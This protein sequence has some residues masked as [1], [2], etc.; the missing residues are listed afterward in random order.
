MTYKE[1]QESGRV[2][3]WDAINDYAVSCGGSPGEHVYGNT[4]RMDAVVEVER[5]VGEIESADLARVRSQRNRL[6]EV[7]DQ[8]LH[9]GG[10]A[11]DMHEVLDEI[12]K[13]EP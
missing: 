7:M 9:E 2:A 4:R 6:R 11:L 8:C 10:D 3:L 5:R 1:L 13:E 12:A